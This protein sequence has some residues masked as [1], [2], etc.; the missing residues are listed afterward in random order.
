LP[1]LLLQG[2]DAL[3]LW[4]QGQALPGLTRTLGIVLLDPALQAAVVYV[5]VFTYLAH[6]QALL[7]YQLDCV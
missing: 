3:L 5:Q 7:A 6:T 2:A 4:R 1:V